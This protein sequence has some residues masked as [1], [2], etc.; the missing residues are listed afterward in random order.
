MKKNE[1]TVHRAKKIEELRKEVEQRKVQLNKKAS[2]KL[3]KEIAQILTLI[4]EKEILEK[5]A[6]TK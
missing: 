2:R 3:R 4:R 6:K 5:E 1:I